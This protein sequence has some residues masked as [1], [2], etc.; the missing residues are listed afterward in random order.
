[1]KKLLSL[2]ISFLFVF[3][4][5][6]YAFAA[7]SSYAV[8]GCSSWAEAE[9]AQAIELGFVPEELQ[10]DYTE[11]ITRQEFAKIALYFSAMQ[12]NCDVEDYSKLYCAYYK[13]VDVTLTEANP[14]DDCSDYYVVQAREAG[15]INGVGNNLFRPERGITREESA[16]MLE[17]AYRSYTGERYVAE[18]EN[19]ESENTVENIDTGESGEASES[20]DK[21]VESAEN[22]GASENSAD[23]L[24]RAFKDNDEIADWAKSSVARLYDWGVMN[25]TGAGLFSPDAYY[26]REQC[27]VTFIRL[28]RSAPL[29]S[30]HDGKSLC[31]Y[32]Q[33][34]LI[35]QVRGADF[36][37]ED[38]VL[39]NDLCT[40]LCGYQSTNRGNIPVIAAIYQNGGMYDLDRVLT[41]LYS[42]IQDIE[43]G[44]EEHLLKVT[45]WDIEKN[46]SVTRTVNLKTREIV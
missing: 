12:C 41:Q 9:I 30:G 7:D 2:L 16:V 24:K 45:G 46:D 39:V 42:V 36:Y 27:I 44:E 8:Q 18:S 40:I 28:Y 31:P 34:E 23:I 6:R 1:M 10:G 29:S 14:F 21:N 33:N 4:G 43:F 20:N 13:N 38:S 32:T 37:H 3:C 15:L 22:D 35:D 11:V 5:T 25:G 17:N 19:S 26:T